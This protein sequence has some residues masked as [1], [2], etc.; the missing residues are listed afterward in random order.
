MAGKLIKVTIVLFVFFFISPSYAKPL[1]ELNL[2]L[3]WY[4]NPDHAPIYVAQEQGFFKEQGLK[5]NII[6]PADPA[7]TVKMVAAD[8]VD[9]GI[10]YQPKYILLK[11][12]KIPVTQVG[13]LVATPLECIVALKGGSIHSIYDFKGKT[14]GYSD[15]GTDLVLLE[16]LLQKAH[17]TM[18]DITLVNVHYDITQSLLSNKIDAATGVMRNYELTELKL[19][20]RP[21]KAFCPE[22]LDMPP[23]SE[24]IFIA[25]KNEIDKAKLAK[26]FAALEKGTQYLIDNPDE[27]WK[28]FIKHHHNMNNRFNKTV[29]YATLPRFALRPGIVD[30]QRIQL[31]EDFIDDMNKYK[32]I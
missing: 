13:T 18:D 11:K 19:A 6:E 26:F 20:A 10:T 23:Y 16:R 22:D 2:M 27:S 28:E 7:D 24:L 12:R 32:N 15:A 1:Q 5:V 25:N 29:W 4:A 14:I 21:G 30:E 3:D 8:K 17:L 31:Y 9:L